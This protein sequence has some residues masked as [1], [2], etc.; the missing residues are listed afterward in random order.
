[1]KLDH[2]VLFSGN[3]YFRRAVEHTQS[4]GVRVTIVSTVKSSPPMASDELRRQA[5]LFV[6]LT[7]IQKLIGRSGGKP[8]NRQDDAPADDGAYDSDFDEDDEL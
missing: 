2:I 5:D 1:D 3:G 4:M 8:S 7:D 6:E